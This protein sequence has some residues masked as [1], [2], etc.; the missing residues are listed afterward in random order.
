MGAFDA[1]LKP[2]HDQ[3]A[4]WSELALDRLADGG[5]PEQLD[6]IGRAHV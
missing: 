6:K 1:F 3:L 5:Q 4:R 2:Q